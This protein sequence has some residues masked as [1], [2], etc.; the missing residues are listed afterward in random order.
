MSLLRR[1]L[2]IGALV[3]AVVSIPLVVV[4]RAIV[5]GV[6]GQDAMPQDIWVRLFG[7]A[8]IALA[9]FH[10]LILRKLEELWWWCW[11]FVI[12][13][14]LSAVLAV[15]HAAIGVPVGSNA[16]PWWVYAVIN[17]LFTSL[18]LGGLAR[19]GQ[20]KPLL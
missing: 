6:M 7:A 17:G 20:E 4:P 1:V 11:A 5:E 18:Y 3:L 15:L 10:V 9:L 16:W 8:G 2:T 19:A 13:D 12:F 14:G